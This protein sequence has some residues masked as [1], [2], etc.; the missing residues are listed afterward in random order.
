MLYMCAYCHHYH[1]E[2]KALPLKYEK[3][4]THIAYKS[5]F[6]VLVLFVMALYVHHTQG[7]LCKLTAT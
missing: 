3:V 5:E 1:L 4:L 6:H 7:S 2:Y